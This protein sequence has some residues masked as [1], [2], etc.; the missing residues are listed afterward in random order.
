LRGY[1]LDKLNLILMG[2]TGAGKSTLVN[3]VMGEAV[4]PV[5]VVTRE[6]KVYSKKMMIPVMRDTEDGR[7][8]LLS[9]TVY[10]HDTVG[11]EIDSEITQKTLEDIRELICQ[12]QEN[13]AERDMTLVWFCVNSRSSRFETYEVELIRKLS[14]EYEIPFVIVITQCFSEEMG[15]LER[16]IERDFPELMMIKI[17]AQECKTRAG[18]IP[19]FGVE[20]LLSRSI[21]DY[22]RSKVHILE[23]KLN[24]LLQ[25]RQEIIQDLREKGEARIASY[26][27]KAE[28][29][30][31]LPVGCI[32]FIHGLCI[33]MISKLNR[34]V[35]I[36]DSKKLAEDIFTSAI[37]G[38]ILTPLMAVPII[39]A[40]A[41]SAYIETVGE[42]YL[43]ALMGIVE[44]FSAVELEDN[45]LMI[46]RIQMEIKKRVGG[47]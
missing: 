27:K 7:Y 24:K 11:L 18:T 25:Q 31:L 30:G 2:K 4:A 19:A 35:G 29:I 8:G 33:K 28:K 13:E 32:P 10:L 37:A 12:A 22:D 39:S 9:K 44:D 15:E 45:D 46:E 20:E 3:A 40:A 17:L 41:A 36:D 14:V 16:Q 5:K 21:L 6:R 42:S 34:I 23:E 47:N 38:A 26:S 43:D 1:E